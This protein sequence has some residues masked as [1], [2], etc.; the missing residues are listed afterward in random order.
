[1]FRNCEIKKCMIGSG[2]PKVCV[3]LTGTNYEEVME[4]AKQIAQTDQSSTIDMVEFRGD[5]LSVLSDYEQ[6]DKILSDVAD[7]LPDIVLLFTI[8][9]EAEGG[10]H[11]MFETPSIYE[12]NRHVIENRLADIVDVE[13]FSGTQ[14]AS[15]LV[16]FAHEHG[17]KIIMSNHD[18]QTTPEVSEIVTRLRSMQKLGA[19]IVKIAVMP[20]NKLHVINLLEAT[21]IMQEQYAE[22]PVVTMSM[23]ELGAISRISGQFTGSAITFASL[24]QA[25]A[26]GQISV[27]AIHPIL[28]YMEICYPVVQ[29]R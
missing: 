1:M 5:Y 10:E 15:E 29:T 13:L 2:R 9:S 8:R 12:I 24:K 14:E 26:P 11:L 27:H 21:V 4:Q 16:S 25:S 18:F 19:D 7:I 23:G 28:D 3:P 22:V 17:V 20:Q 6:L